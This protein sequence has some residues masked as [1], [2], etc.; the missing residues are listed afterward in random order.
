M[1]C[2]HSPQWAGGRGVAG[3]ETPMVYGHVNY[4]LWEARVITG[5]MQYFYR[6]LKVCGVIWTYF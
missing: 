2:E 3:G 6:F 1:L 4:N 5:H